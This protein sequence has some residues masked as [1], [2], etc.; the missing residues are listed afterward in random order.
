MRHDGGKQAQAKAI[1]AEQ[2][3]LPAADATAQTGV[4]KVPWLEANRDV[5]GFDTRKTAAALMRAA[6]CNVDVT[7]DESTALQINREIWGNGGP[8]RGGQ[9]RR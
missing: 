8:V 1:V 2:K 9:I 7:F 4:S 5:L 6:K 3:Q